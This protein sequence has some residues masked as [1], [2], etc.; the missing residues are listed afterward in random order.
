MSILTT[1]FKQLIGGVD[2]IARGV[3][4]TKDWLRFAIG[5]KIL[6]RFS[7]IEVR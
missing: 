4:R 3:T 7:Y 6:L 2:C 5:T 1:W